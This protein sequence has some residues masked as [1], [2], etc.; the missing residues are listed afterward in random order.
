MRSTEFVSTGAIFWQDYWSHACHYVQDYSN[1]R[2]WPFLTGGLLCGQ[3][4]YPNHVMFEYIGVPW[5]PILRH[6]QEMQGTYIV[7][8]KKKHVLSFLIAKYFGL[9]FFVQSTLYGDKGNNSKQ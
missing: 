5:E 4:G 3:S 8:N 9:D 7:I 2:E 6:A 1:P